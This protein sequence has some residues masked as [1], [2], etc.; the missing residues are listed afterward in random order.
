MG[1]SSGPSRH[2][3]K[4]FEEFVKHVLAVPKTEL[5]ARLDKEKRKKRER[6]KR[7]PAN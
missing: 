6:A 5:D 4:T 2:P 1:S 3:R 7:P